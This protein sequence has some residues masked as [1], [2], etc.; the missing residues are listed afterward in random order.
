MQQA[1]HDAGSI[2]YESED[3]KPIEE[4]SRYDQL[5]DAFPSVTYPL[6]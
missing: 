4:H 3:D 1:V 6:S 5:F 2:E